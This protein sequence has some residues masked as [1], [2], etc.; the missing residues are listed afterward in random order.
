MNRAAVDALAQASNLELFHLSVILNRLMS[1]PARILPLRMKL[2]IGQTVRFVDPQ[3]SDVELRMRSA[4]VV[5]M[6]ALDVVL[7]DGGRQWVVPYI[8]VEIPDTEGVEKSS[9]PSQPAPR[10]PC[11]DDFQVGDS[12]S[13]D[14]THLRTRMA[15]II[16]INQK[17]ATLRCEDGTEWRVAYV[18][19]RP[20][21]DI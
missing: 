19:L 3:A 9:A 15:R 17:T 21:I 14:D 13:F 11:R 5:N 7:Q 8:A 20:M 16:R 18:Y 6:K 12:V 1:D 4:K 10:R 2:Q